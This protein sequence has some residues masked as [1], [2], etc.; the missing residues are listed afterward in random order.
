[1]AI[2]NTNKNFCYRICHIRNLPH[3][4]KHGICTKSHPNADPNYISI[5][6]TS[7]I[8]V[9][10]STPVKIPD[11]G[12]IGD[13]VPF[14]FTPKSMMFYNIITGYQDPLVPKQN[15]EDIIVIRCLISDLCQAGKFFFTDGQ[16][17]VK[18]LTNHYNNLNDLD[19]IDWDI[20]QKG[21]FKKEEA[22]TDK[23]RRYQAEFL[24]HSHVPVNLI[25]SINVYNN[26]A[27]TFVQTELAKTTII[28]P[29]FIQKPYFF[30]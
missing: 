27:F 25:Q 18:S 2:L 5:G 24:V 7:I 19:K 11:Y 30:E 10:D 20:I 15:K 21:D 13:Y 1:M 6:N 12:N 4:L 14:Y 26:K 22:D 8:S 17:N 16:A 3:L 29:V 28:K 23:Q 9:R